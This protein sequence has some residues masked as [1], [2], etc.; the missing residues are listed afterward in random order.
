MPNKTMKFCVF[1]LAAWVASPAAAVTF[2]VVLTGFGVARTETLLLPE[3]KS[4][5]AYSIL[6]SI[7]SASF[8]SPDGRVRIAVSQGATILV[9]KTLHLGDPDLY[10]QFRVPGDG[11]G[12]VKVTVS[13]A[14]PRYLCFANIASA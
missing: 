12:Q 4:G 14:M 7:E 8:L 11:P 1:W 13:G 6:Y 10:A 5:S 2:P 9:Q 3:L